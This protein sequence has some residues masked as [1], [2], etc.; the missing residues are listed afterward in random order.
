MED[1][2][3][4]VDKLVDAEGRHLIQVKQLMANQKGTTMCTATAEIQ[5]PKKP[6]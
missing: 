1:S 3:N 5:L 2:Q 6:D 4:M